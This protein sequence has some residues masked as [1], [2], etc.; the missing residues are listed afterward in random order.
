MSMSVGRASDDL[1]QSMTD[2]FEVRQSELLA[3]NEMF[4]SML[5]RV[6]TKL[7]AISEGFSLFFLLL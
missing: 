7:E 1:Q 3:E 5:V 4:R 2:R 6:Q